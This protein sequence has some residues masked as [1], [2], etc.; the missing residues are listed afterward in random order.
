MRVIGIPIVEHCNLNCKGCL[1]L[2]HKGQKKHFED[3]NQIDRDLKRLHDFYPELEEIH[4]YGGEPFLHPELTTIIRSIRMCYAHTHIIIM[5]NGTLLRSAP[6][7]LLKTISETGT[8]IRWTV[9]PV[10]SE[11]SI[12]LTRNTLLENQ[13]HWEENKV[14]N[15]YKCF[16]P[17][18]EKKKEESFSLC[19]GKHCHILKDGRLY[20]CPAP[21]IAEYLE[22][23]GGFIPQEK[24]W[25]DLYRKGLST[26]EIDN[27]LHTPLDVCAYCGKPQFFTW[28]KQN[29][30]DLADWSCQ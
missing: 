10:F 29:K 15:F 4:V 17:R 5:T 18:G 16:Y 25:L 22:E 21:A 23:M 8:F 24:A 2:C 3:S 13:V 20:V 7:A 11:D 6:E 9:Y 1:H 27:F 19:S 14:T 28:E 30:P 26:A 12:Q